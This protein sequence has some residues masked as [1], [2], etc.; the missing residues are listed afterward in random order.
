MIIGIDG[1]E[2]NVTSRVGVSVYAGELL[3]RF[4]QKATPQLHF[5]VFLRN[6]PLSHMPKPSPYFRYQVVWGPVGWSQI[7]LPMKL[8]LSSKLDVFFAPAHYAPRFLK[9]PLVVTIHDVSYLKYPDEFLSHDLYKLTSWTADALEK[10]KAVIAVSKTT[11][12]DIMSSYDIDPSLIRVIYNGFQRHKTLPKE[13]AVFEEY[14]ISPKNYI[15][16]VGT[17]Q[18]RKNIPLLIEA[19]SQFRQKYPTMKLVLVGKKGWLFQEIFDTIEKHNLTEWV[20]APGYVDD[21]SLATL[22]SQSFCYVLPSL[23]EG[24][25]IPILEAMNYQTP[26]IS[27]HSS[28]LPEIGGDACL[29]FDPTDS[30]D[31]LEKLVVLKEES[32]LR[33]T[34]ISAGNA[35]VQSFS[36]DQCAKETLDLLI[37]I[38]TE[39]SLAKRV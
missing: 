13:Q 9:A 18:P 19:F 37:Q 23:Y 35:R 28:S 30:H 1:N 32:F 4:A 31:L 25:G 10:A 38:A 34:L 12:K 20:V 5:V 17:L 3:H 26:V 27:S 14:G 2:A 24:F 8:A 21:T 39:S 33:K 6:T 22:Y 29:Y 16:Y 15:L 11:K 36:W 7:F